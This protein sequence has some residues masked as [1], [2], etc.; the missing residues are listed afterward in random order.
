M[1]EAFV[2]AKTERPKWVMITFSVSVVAHVIAGYGLVIYS[3]WRIEK[4]KARYVAVAFMAFPVP[5]PPPPPPPSPPAPKAA[6]IHVEKSKVVVKELVQPRVAVIAHELKA[7]AAP[8]P[9]TE[10]GQEGGVTGGV[11]GGVVG[12]TVAEVAPPPAPPAAPKVVQFDTIAS[13]M[14]SGE[15]EIHLPT[16]ALQI[17]SNQGIKQTVVMIKFCVDAAGS[18]ST[19]DVA[20]SSGLSEADANGVAKV[21]EWKFRPYMVNGGAVTVCAAKMFRYVIE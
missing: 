10:E 15:K 17:L 21:R 7:L 16:A 13:A 2:V 12:G 19:V 5:P 6:T 14:I 18:V 9:P 8:T 11:A 20:K 4:L 1:F 3:F